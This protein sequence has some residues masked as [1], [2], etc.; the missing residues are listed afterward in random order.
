LS[1]R[2]TGSADAV[3]L[4]SQNWREVFTDPGLQKLIDEALTAGPDA[5]LAGPTA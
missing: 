1:V 3:S 2:R 4:A 5:L